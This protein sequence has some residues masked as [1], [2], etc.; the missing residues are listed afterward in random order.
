MESDGRGSILV[1]Q[2]FIWLGNAS[3]CFPERVPAE[4]TAEE[5]RQGRNALPRCQLSN[6]DI[7]VLR[8]IYQAPP[9]SRRYG[10]LLNKQHCLTKLGLMT[11]QGSALPTLLFSL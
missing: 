1:V 7:E 10:F 11:S 6:N 9:S 5:E 4:E 2:A 8:S 3:A